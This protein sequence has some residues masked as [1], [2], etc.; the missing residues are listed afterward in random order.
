MIRRGFTLLEAIIA[1]VVL[2]GVAIACLEM[3]A[4]A[5]VVGRRVD[6]QQ[7]EEETARVTLEMAIAGLLEDGEGPT[8]SDPTQRILWKGDR[9]GVPYVCQ[10]ERVQMPNPALAW[11]ADRGGEEA[12]AETLTL[13]RYS[14]TAGD[15]SLELL[16]PVKP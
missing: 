8:P 11:A 10:R 13:D 4:R 14:V 6:T 16:T 5:M 3:R 7:R 2:G 12:L 1:L 9:D 15:V